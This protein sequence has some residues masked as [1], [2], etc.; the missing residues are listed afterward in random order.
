MPFSTVFPPRLLSI[1]ALHTMKGLFSF[2]QK[3]K[4]E[5]LLRRSNC[6]TLVN[7]DFFF[8]AGVKQGVRNTQMAG[9][10]QQKTGNCRTYV[11]FSHL[12]TSCQNQ[13]GFQVTLIADNFYCP[14]VSSAVPSVT[15]SWPFF[16]FFLLFCNWYW[17]A[18]VCFPLHSKIITWEVNFS[19][20]F[21]S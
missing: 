12:S 4:C 17:I 18:F 9:Q 15:F 19:C 5:S 20:L 11:S 13:H 6:G 14:V 2:V 8:F 16:F 7:K 1:S 10:R 21:S 3:K